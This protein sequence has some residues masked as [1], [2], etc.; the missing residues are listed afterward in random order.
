MARGDAMRAL[1][2]FGASV[3]AD[4]IR[5]QPMSAGKVR[6]AWQLA[7]GAGLS[8]A[9]EAEFEGPATIRVRAKDARWAAEIARSR[10]VLRERLETLLGVRPLQLD[11]AEP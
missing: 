5:R 8:R 11:I 1:P 9:A 2:Q 7:A 6:L 3:L 4:V 10:A